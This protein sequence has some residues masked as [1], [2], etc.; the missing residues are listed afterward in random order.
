MF[1]F[2]LLQSDTEAAVC[3]L[4]LVC[5]LLSALY[6]TLTLRASTQAE[7]SLAAAVRSCQPSMHKVLLTSVLSK[8]LTTDQKNYHP[9][10]VTFSFSLYSISLYYSFHS[11]YQDMSVAVTFI[12][13]IY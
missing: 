5:K 4:R 12:L 6:Y 13:I 8:Y 3:E 7:Q 1:K 9:T 10:R 2:S 11:T